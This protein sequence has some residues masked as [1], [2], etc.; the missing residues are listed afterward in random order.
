MENILLIKFQKGKKKNSLQ[1]WSWMPF[2]KFAK[3]ITRELQLLLKFLNLLLLFFH[4]NTLSPF[5]HSLLLFDIDSWLWK[6]MTAW[7]MRKKN[8]EIK[9]LKKKRILKQ[10][11]LLNIVL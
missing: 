11:R 8:K 2:K 3:A 4:S 9:N 7:W 1:Y 5:L 10:I 6:V